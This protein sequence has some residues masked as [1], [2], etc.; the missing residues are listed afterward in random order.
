VQQ[1]SGVAGLSRAAF[2]RR[3]RQ[4]VGAAPMAYLTDIRRPARPV[5]GRGQLP[6]RVTL[7]IFSLL[8][9]GML[10]LSPPVLVV[11][12]RLPSVD[13]STVRSRP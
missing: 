7:K 12:H 10:S 5:P 2:T 4:A 1:L 8:L 6:P 9:R 3:F 13:G 11:S